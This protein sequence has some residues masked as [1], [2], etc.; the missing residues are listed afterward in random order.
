VLLLE[1]GDTDDVPSVTEAARWFENLG[2][3]RDWKFVAQPNPHLK[4]RSMP[5]SMG[6]VLV[7]PSAILSRRAGGP[8]QISVHGI[9]A[10][11]ADDVRCRRDTVAK[12]ENQTTPK[13]S[14]KLIL[15]CLHGCN[16]P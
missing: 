8:R 13:I 7:R 9:Y 12:V 5:L 1:A 16:P 14:R 4:G 2:S 15:S 6:K 3:E 10:A 11:M